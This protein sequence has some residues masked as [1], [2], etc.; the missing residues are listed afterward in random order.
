MTKGVIRSP[1]LYTAIL[2]DLDE[3]HA[4]GEGGHVRAGL[5][6]VGD[7]EDG[8]EGAGYA[9]HCGEESGCSAQR[10]EAPQGHADPLRPGKL[11][12]H[13]ENDHTGAHASDDEVGVGGYEQE[14]AEDGKGGGAGDEPGDHLPVREFPVQPHA[15]EGADELEYGNDRHRHLGTVEPHQHGQNQ[16]AAAEPRDAGQRHANG[17]DD[18]EDRQLPEDQ[19][20]QGSH[21]FSRKDGQTH[22]HTPAAAGDIAPN[23]QAWPLATGMSESV[24][25]QPSKA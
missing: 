25:E 16:D 11:G 21:S 8:R 15:G 24:E 4:E 6:A 19:V 9:H 17:R 20:F 18:K 7:V 1:V 14:A 23:G 3:E 10:E 2:G 5:E 13:H 22:N 12:K